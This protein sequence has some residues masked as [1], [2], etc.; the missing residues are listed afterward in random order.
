MSLDAALTRFARLLRVA[1]VPV[2]TD[3]VL[4]ATDALR[5][6]GLTR[7]GDVHATLAAVMVSRREHAAVFDAAFARFWAAPRA[8]GLPG[9]EPDAYGQSAEPA[10]DDAT[11]R[12][13]NAIAQ[14]DGAA[15]AAPR[16][17]DAAP[18]PDAHGSA[19]PDA[20][21]RDAD[22]QHLSAEQLAQIHRHVA[23]LRIALEPV[24]TRRLAPT[25]DVAGRIDLRATLRTA[26]REGGDLLHLERRAPRW[27]APPL[28]V[29]CDL[30][31]SMRRYASVLL[32]LAHALGRGAERFHAFVFTT[33]LVDI[34]P[35]LAHRDA[36]AA[37][38]AVETV[39]DDFA[40]GTRIGASL[41]TFN[42]HHARRVL[43][44]GATLLLFTD[45]LERGDPAL[46]AAEAVH[47]RR[48][49]RHVLWLNPLLRH[50]GFEPVARGM[51]ALLPATDALL[52]AHNL[53]SLDA[54]VTVL[55][56][57]ARADPVS[58]PLPTRTRHGHDRRTIAAAASPARM[59]SPRRPRGAE[60]VHPGLRER[61]A[62]GR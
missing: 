47:L 52:P 35:R 13:E 60:A 55:G 40:G 14:L 3:R 7:R 51:Q 33:R 62:H 23:R 39:V 49:C 5:A 58:S 34:T 38:R 37:L 17:E 45:G 12:V 41:R 31:G 9:V 25:A 4:A 16:D 24:R 42:L 1:G 6:V 44:S 26:L 19:S 27:R 59:G 2:G 28:V 18:T 20:S 29:I 54:L 53:A 32:H 46:L 21:L 57:P 15:P 50:D 8:A 43:G 56:A 11:W 61:R 30:S 22:F 48:L 10:P 36:D